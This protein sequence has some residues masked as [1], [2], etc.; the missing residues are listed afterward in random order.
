MSKD[1]NAEFVE[2]KSWKNL[3]VTLKSAVAL[4]LEPGRFILEGQPL[5]LEF[6]D[7]QMVE[8]RGTHKL[9][10]PSL[11]RWLRWRN[12]VIHL[13]GHH[14]SP[15]HRPPGA[16]LEN[17]ARFAFSKRTFERV[18]KPHLADTQHEYFEA[19]KEGDLRT[20]RWVRVRGML[21][22]WSHVALQWPVSLTRI[23]QRLWTISGG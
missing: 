9:S 23:V 17:F 5:S 8:L 19:L 7:V 12:A 3:Q 1:K 16:K 21:G 15:I 14:G 20:A 2:L 4:E 18:F 11:P 6:K 13:V 22:F 10:G